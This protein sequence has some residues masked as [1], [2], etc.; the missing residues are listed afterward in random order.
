LPLAGGTLTGP[1]TLAAD[2][3]APLGAST[4]QYVDATNIRYRNRIINGD[5]SVD[6]RHGG[7]LVAG[8]VNSSSYAIDRWGISSNSAGNIG[9]SLTSGGSVN[10][11]FSYALN[12]TT[13]TA[14]TVVAADVT[15]YYHGIEGCNF[16]DANFGLANAQP[17]V[18]EFWA[19]SSLTGTFA[20]GLQNGAS[21]RS[22]VFTYSLPTA[23][24]WTKIRISIP[25]DT[26]GT[27]Q[28]AG[29]A[30]AAYLLFN[31]GAGSTFAHATGSW[32]PG[33]FYTVAGAV[34]PV[35]T[36]NAT[37]YITGVALMVGAA[38]ANAEPEFK[39]YA[40][41]LIDCQRYFASVSFRFQGYTSTQTIG[42]SISLP[43]TM[44]TTTPIL[45]PSITNSG[46][47]TSPT[48][49]NT[50]AHT[51]YIAGT[52]SAAGGFTLLGTCTADADF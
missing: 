23:N 22:Y 29:N 42:Y 38:A 3:T 9:Q 46:G 24:T 52:G 28:V 10:N 51:I 2:P 49:G 1:L 18:L 15:G 21:A 19:Q 31:V 44:R 8:P 12:W 40:D 43:V 45:T 37:F 30:V 48:M 7:A 17:V 14:H 13:T 26:A 4:K 32:A 11:Q 33:N 35:A 27:W 41:N 6:A 5:M 50:D 34:N 36:A 47:V 39:K 16:N 25:G 20:G